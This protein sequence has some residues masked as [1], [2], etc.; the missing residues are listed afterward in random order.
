MPKGIP[1]SE[2][3]KIG[4]RFDVEYRKMRRKSKSDR[5]ARKSQKDK[6]DKK[7]GC[8]CEK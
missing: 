5:A 3:E 8:K 1:K 6:K 4:E 2:G 7:G